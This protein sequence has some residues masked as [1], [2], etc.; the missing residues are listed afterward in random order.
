MP[1][2]LSPAGLPSTYPARRLRLLPW[3]IGWVLCCGLGA[4]AT[5]LLWP[6]QTS[7]GGAWFWFCL[8][9]V[10]NAVFFFVL[11]VART[12]YEADYLYALL[13][14]RHRASWLERRI[15][16]AQEP[17]LVLG[18]GYYLPLD[19]KSIGEV[20][21]GISPLLEARVPRS[22]MG[23]VMHTRFADDDPIFEAATAEPAQLD[24]ALFDTVDVERDQATMPDE[25]LAST[26]PPVV[27]VIEQALAPLVES[28]RTLSLL[29]PQYAP[30]VRVMSAF[31]TATMRVEQVKH[32]LQRMGLGA[33]ECCGASV[34][35][36]LMVVDAWLDAAEQR[37]L[38]VVAAEWYDA[39]PPESTEGAVAVLLSPGT[40]QRP[41]SLSAVGT[42]HR[43][44]ADDFGDL[45][46][47]LSNSALWGITEASTVATAWISG[48]DRAH[49]GEWLAALRSA[50]FAGVTTPETQRLP[51]RMI[52]L[53]GAAGGWL[54]IAAA[55]ET[56]AGPQLIFHIPSGT[57]TAQAA[58]LHINERTNE[59][60]PDDRCTQ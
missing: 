27:R 40:L 22:G 12:T 49:D 24:D 4:A 47:V 32:A 42:L 2:D 52:G 53:A 28:I 39:P 11:A 50:G 56:S 7:T 14:N 20:V 44:V 5:V 46:A 13:R 16:V 55:L 33:L 51:D 34:A 3:F 6:A 17:L 21:G 35:D 10:P 30:A 58:I 23:R 19:G 25:I 54:S 1:V 38:L 37:A 9:G 31:D 48:L 8:F 29:G 43:P 45:D 36:G 60:A 57:A 41:E 18:A 26:V 59:D 15:R